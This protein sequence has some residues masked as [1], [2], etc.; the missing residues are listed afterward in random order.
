MKANYNSIAPFYDGLSR[1][2][3]GDAIVN[4]QKFLVDAIVPNS[5]IL[6]VGGGTGWILEEISKKHSTGLQIIYVDI[7]QK[8]IELSKRR[9]IGNNK[10]IFLNAD[11]QNVELSETFDVVITPFLLD[12]F[13]PRTA[14]LVFNKIHCRLVLDGL[15]L[16]SDFQVSD[17][18]NLWQKLLL[19]VMYFFFIVLCNIEA[20]E[21]PD[22][23][24]LFSKNS[25]RLVSSKTFFHRFICSFIYQ[26]QDG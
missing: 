12:N 7:S 20:T 15:W 22:T 17:K 26:K 8:M 5:T 6:I 11:I 2:I 25:Y 24:F 4:A 18:R 13:S 3:Y 19:K 16:F 23:N 21:L 9:Y 10:V 1:L 14:N